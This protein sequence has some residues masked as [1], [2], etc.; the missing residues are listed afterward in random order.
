MSSGITPSRLAAL[1]ALRLIDPKL[2]E[3]EGADAGAILDRI[4]SKNPLSE[5]DRRL[6][7]ELVYGVLRQRGHLDAWIEQYATAP[8][9]RL[10]PDPVLALR[11]ALYQILFLKKIPDSAAVN[12]AVEW[13][14]GRLGKSPA[15]LVNGI[16][17]E[18]V[19]HPG[20]FRLPD[21]GREPVAHLSVKHAH[22]SWM[23]ARWLSRLGREPTEALLSANNAAPPLTLRVNSRILTQDALIKEI[24]A[25]G[26]EAEPTAVSPVGL[27][28]RGIS[29]REIPAY[30]RGGF[31]VQDEAAQ[32]VSCLVGPQPG[33]RVLDACAAPG[34]KATHLVELMEGK[35]EV[36][37]WDRSEE[38]L[39]TLKENLERM[40]AAI[41]RTDRVDALE[42]PEESPFD[43]ILLDAP[44]SAL[45][46]LRRAPEG[47]WGKGESIISR[48]ASLQ[49]KMLDRLAPL[50]R[51]GG[52]LVY[53][54]C[55]T[56]PEENEEVI[57]R[58]LSDHPEFERVSA[59]SALPQ[60]G[61]KLVDERGYFN[62]LLNPYRMDFF[63]AAALVKKRM[64]G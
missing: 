9:V 26:G 64:D 11:L 5:K 36:V 4:L 49:W 34:G 12:T 53:A 33:E 54:T 31:Y 6:A 42:P 35:G 13:V 21:P 7:T 20:R 14:K 52:K 27:I 32:L 39:A 3:G 63:F 38:R 47:K 30:Q 16:L 55:S 8:L 59:A 29:P 50:L 1:E 15:G 37:A 45:G 46:I 62:S 17:R 58:F 28:V 57:E 44:C 61:G 19:R 56:E 41:V 48:C 18:V 60:G 43:R 24:T 2:E 23:V 40:G 22:P 10:P 51:R 25:A